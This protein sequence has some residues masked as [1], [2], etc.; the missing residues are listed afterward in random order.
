MALLLAAEDDILGAIETAGLSVVAFWRS[1]RARTRRT[2]I[3]RRSG[4]GYRGRKERDQLQC[5]SSSFRLYQQETYGYLRSSESQHYFG[6]FTAVQLEGWF[7]ASSEP[8]Q[9]GCGEVLPP[10]GPM[11]SDHRSPKHNWL[12]RVT[13]KI[14]NT[15]ARFGLTAAERK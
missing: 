4:D 10:S 12:M 2:A 6:S 1:W 8:P 11:P 7:S 9:S 15:L 13:P 3:V 14:E 5:K